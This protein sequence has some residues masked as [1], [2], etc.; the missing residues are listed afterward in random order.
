MK[1]VTVIIVI[2]LQCLL[3][4]LKILSE[5]FSSI[6]N[7]FR[8]KTSKL[9]RYMLLDQLH[10]SWSPNVHSQEFTPR[11]H[12]IACFIETCCHKVCQNVTENMAPTNKGETD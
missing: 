1:Y 7:A 6:F 4:L 10:H 8:T 5:P 3:A 2:R 12:E 9:A 11:Y